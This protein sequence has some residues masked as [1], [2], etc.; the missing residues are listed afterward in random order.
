MPA[1]LSTYTMRYNVSRELWRYFLSSVKANFKPCRCCHRDQAC[2]HGKGY[3][4][5]LG[6]P[7]VMPLLM[8]RL[9]T[10]LGGGLAELDVLLDPP[11]VARPRAAPESDA[12]VRR[13]RAKQVPQG[14]PGKCE[15]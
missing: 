15:H 13:A 1:P 8:G 4:F 5:S 11:G 7:L 10:V 3:G 9:L 2:D 6:E 14:V 12:G